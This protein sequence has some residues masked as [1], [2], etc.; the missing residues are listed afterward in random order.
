MLRRIGKLAAT[1]TV[2]T[3]LMF[4]AV[5][6]LTA[7]G[8]S[9]R[10]L[11]GA[12]APAISPRTLSPAGFDASFADLA[13]APPAPPLL[14]NLDSSTVNPNADDEP[15]LPIPQHS[16]RRPQNEANTLPPAARPKRED[17]KFITSPHR[18]STDLPIP[19][20]PGRNLAGPGEVESPSTDPS[21]SDA[22]AGMFPWIP[23]RI[24]NGLTGEFIYT[25]D[26]F[27][28]ARGGL[29]TRNAT[30]YIGNL[31]VVF[32]FDTEAAGLWKGGQLFTYL[33][34]INGATLSRN[35]TQDF[36]FYDVLDST[37]RSNH[38]TQLVEMWYVQS[39]FDGKLSFKLG[40]QDSSVN[41]AH[42]DFA[43]DFINASFTLVPT[44]PLPTYPN[45]GYGI[46][47]FW[48][49]NDAWLFSAGIY[50][51]VFAGDSSALAHLGTGGCVSLYQIDY[52]PQG[53]FFKRRPG[54][55][56]LGGFYHTGDWAQITTAPDPLTYK[57]NYGMWAT[58]DQMLWAEPNVE[59]QGLGLFAQFGWSPG[60]RNLVQE[61]YCAGF[62]YKGLL[63]RRDFDVLGIG[64]TDVLF[65]KQTF[66]RD[67]L[68]F[69]NAIET[70]YRFRVTPNV[71]LQPDAQFLINPGGNGRD[72]FVVGLR[73]EMVL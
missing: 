28:N 64:F 40:K 63:P 34:S 3:N 18:K 72:A 53:R 5:D 6:D 7:E 2:V 11:F 25:G 42:N 15:S 45:P 67:G 65:G 30:R 59:E 58:I 17:H 29:A 10:R 44:V 12:P 47:S 8:P 54:I 66:E 37:P 35:F 22:P 43:G 26:T 4:V 20:R 73:C 31:D 13:E 9:S 32:N 38:Y 62:V 41:F 70:F 68:K 55:Y 51:A 16:R 60:N 71:I 33:Q 23:H 48:K 27:N 52:L 61:N 19:G 50:D 69:E 1:L 39:L 46:A 24:G 49:P 57:Y 36:Q 14:P 56:R 21:E